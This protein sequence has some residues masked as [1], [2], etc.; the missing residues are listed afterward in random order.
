MMKLTDKRKKLLN[1]IFSKANKFSFIIDLIIAVIF[2]CD[3]SIV[4]ALFGLVLACFTV[5]RVIKA[6]IKVKRSK[7][8]AYDYLRNN[9]V[10]A[11]EGKQRVGKTSLA[12][13]FISVMNEDSFSNIPLKIKGKYT[14]KL[15]TAHL[16]C[17]KK[18][19][20]YS[21][22]FIDECNLFYN[23]LYQEKSSKGNNSTIFGQAMLEQCIGHFTDGNMIYS[24]TDIERL[25][26]E[27]RKN[28]S[29]TGR[30]L[31]QYTENYSI[32]GSLLLKLIYKILGY[33]EVYTGLRCWKMQ[34]F[35]RISSYSENYYFDL[36][37]ATT[38]TENKDIYSPV[39]HFAA[40]ND[41][42]DFEYNDRFMLGL[43][44]N[45]NLSNSDLWTDL[46]F[47]FK[48]LPNLYD[49]QLIKYM[50]QKE[51]NQFSDNDSNE[52]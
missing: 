42:T 15:E 4:F 45:L 28:I 13:Y 3:K 36:S 52:I 14:N 31:E 23:N 24:S 2:I 10:L 41:F 29:A 8:I 12:C 27:I 20:E 5:Y 21:V 46:E 39:Y 30:V 9:R 44:K 49:S 43:Y 22:L 11:L 18:L 25:P 38:E 16:S 34:H 32:F 1:R 40:Y 48:D 35:E 47:N 19:P 17:D 7:T 26:S 6:Y 37:A 51:Y 33:K 50:S